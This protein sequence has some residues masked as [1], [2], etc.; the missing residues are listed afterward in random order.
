MDY[1][2]AGVDID[3]G[4]RLVASIKAMMGGEGA[5][6]GHFGGALRLP[7]SD[8][9][10]LIAS[11]DGVGTKIEIA[12]A[13]GRFDTIGQ[14]L[15]HH[16]INDIACC[17]AEPVG[18]LDYYAAASLNV[19]QA[20]EVVRGIIT[21]CRRWGVSLM[22][23]ET[24]EMPGIYHSDKF[25]LAGVIF[26]LVDHSDYIDGR[27]IAA[28]DWIVGL[29]SNGP[30]TNGYSLVRRVIAD[31]GLTYNDPMPGGGSIGDAL[32]AVHTCYL[33]D[34]HSIKNLGVI[35]GLA[36]ITG[37]GLEGN[38]KRIIPKGLTI[39]INWEAWD[40]PAIF[41]FLKRIGHIADAEMRRVFNCGIGLTAVMDPAAAG[42]VINELNIGA[43]K[44]GEVVQVN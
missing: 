12:A 32:L 3:K 25:D 42:G 44:I 18:F 43:V 41:P 5:A 9:K 37:G 38:L 11:I 34:I 20:A 1:R 27:S 36:H 6:I 28:G 21:A 30:H 33:N 39:N 29:P 19:E 22:G 7:D 8:G 10:L 17:G 23:G 35:K 2:K 16:C 24:A 40:Q 31:A 14:D 4:D 26:G 15:V 13:M